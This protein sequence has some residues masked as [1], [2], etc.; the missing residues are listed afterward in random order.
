MYAIYLIV[1][2]M[3]TVYLRRF[4]Q[5][6]VRLLRTQVGMFVLMTGSL[7]VAKLLLLFTALP[8][9][10]MPVA[11]LPLW[12]AIAFDRRTAF[13]VEVGVAFIASSLLRFDV[14]LLSV[15]LVRGIAATMFFFKRKG[16][17]QLFVAGSLAGIAGAIGFIALTVLFEG[18]SISAPI[19]K[20]WL[21]SNVLACVG[22]GCSSACSVGA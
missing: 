6:R 20:R 7:I 14:V 19:S 13:L 12:V 21:G 22:G 8:E 4:G 5:N 18:A 1:C 10:W 15:L 11:A 16:S 2:L 9:F 17:R 3:L